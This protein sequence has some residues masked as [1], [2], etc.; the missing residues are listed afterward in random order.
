MND[1][2]DDIDVLE[3]AVTRRSRVRVITMD[4]RLFVDRVL[5]VITEGGRDFARFEREGNL[6]LDRI[7]RVSAVDRDELNLGT[8]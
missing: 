1:R 5:D 7:R 8:D 4:D 6:P 2:C 3:E